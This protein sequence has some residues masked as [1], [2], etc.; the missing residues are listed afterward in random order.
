MTE[1]RDEKQTGGELTPDEAT[2]LS[3][4]LAGVARSGLPLGPGLRALAE[5]TPRGAFRDALRGL[6]DAIERGVPLEQAIASE[7]GAIPPH[8]RGLIRAGLRTGDLGEV[9]GRFSAVAT[10]GAELKRSFW[11]GLAYPLF[12]IALAVV[13][14]VLVDV[15]IVSRFE[16]IFMDF[17]ISLPVMTRVLLFVSHAARTG[18]PILA[19]LLAVLLGAWLFTGLVLSRATRNS[20]FARMPIIGALWRYTSWAEFCHLLAMLLESKLPLPEALRLTGAG[21][22]DADVHLACRAMA[23]QVEKGAALSTAMEGESIATPRGPFGPLDP[24]EPKPATSE[25]G[26]GDADFEGSPAPALD[27]LV[28]A[29]A[30]ARAIRRAMPRGLPRLLRWA[31]DRA[32]TVEVLKMAAET[33]QARSRAESSFGGAVLAFLAMVGVFLGVAV[34]VIGMF[35]PL[36]T[37]V[38]KLSG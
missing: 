22:E 16:N 34:I 11:L 24:G 7:A 29:R 8:L 36:I 38:S 21:V 15:L 3:Q 2:R 12:A 10:V 25:G 14:W 13:L 33:F 28:D 20:L 35:L 32:A 26:A 6:A 31:E 18:W 1:P 27:D 23:L 5:E 37:L 30:G 17:G 19:A 4:H 9:L